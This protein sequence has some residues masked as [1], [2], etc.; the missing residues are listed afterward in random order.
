MVLKI[1]KQN[2]SNFNKHL[3]LNKQTFNFINHQF[4]FSSPFVI[5]LLSSGLVMCSCKCNQINNNVEVLLKK[6][7]KPQACF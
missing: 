4:N 1:E 2:K 7:K 5:S 6:K 3:N